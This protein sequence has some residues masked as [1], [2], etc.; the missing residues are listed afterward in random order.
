[1][2]RIATWAIAWAAK[3]A[4]GPFAR[5][6]ADTRAAQESLLATM[7]QRNRGTEYGRE[8]GFGGIRTLAE[9]A[10]RVPVVDYEDLRTRIERVTLGEKNV[11]TAEDP[12]LF[13]QTSGTTGKPKFIP[14]T[15]T[16]RKS[17]GLTVWLHY[18]RQDHPRM[19]RGRILTIVSP[20]V[21][22]YTDGNLP[23]GSTSGMV[24]KEMPAFVRS[25]YAVPYDAF[26]I[27]N[28]E[29]KYYALLRFGIASDVTFLATANPSSVLML[30]EMADRHAESLIR[31]I[32]DGALSNEFEIPP[33][34][35]ALLA[36]ALAAD[37]ARARALEAMRVRR[38]RLVPADYWPDLALLGCW[39]GGTVGSYI[40]KLDSWYDPD[41]KGMPP[42]RDMGYLASEAR[43][44]V[45]VS[46]RG[47]GGVLTIHNNVFELVPA[48]EVDERP[49]DHESWSY[50]PAA[51]A[52]VGREYYVFITT[53]GGL[54]RYDIND[55]IEVVDRYRT[56]PVVE[57]RRKGRGMTNMTGEK[58]SVN[59]LIDAMQ[60]AA[61]SVS[62]QLLHFRG[63][64]DFQESRYV[65][66]VELAGPLDG[67]RQ[68]ELLA[69]IDRELG[70]RNIEYQA[71]RNSDR[72]RPPVLQVMR[73]GWY[74][75]GKQK[76][77]DEGK[78]LFQAKTILLDA[79]QGYRPEPEELEAES[80]LGKH[81]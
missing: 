79:K 59:Q 20:A 34:I 74:E 52:E 47:S 2:S 77:V 73:Q 14:V 25:A 21:E 44:S 1:M 49:D 26:E 68:G 71:K 48:E 4:A 18:A 58:L 38:G 81:E 8:F 63:E 23:Y 53:P 39:K 3:R 32:R 7:M 9:Y 15:P 67:A 28:Y 55:V 12:V 76:L 62:A 54:Y 80:R 24:V 11:L 66:K 61:R 19:F 42:I 41:G 64:P 30:A 10:R 60:E 43:M 50:L 33:G 46:D 40:R 37:P 16:C 13:A 75:R 6:V 35:R 27:A 56:A 72:L 5:A 22:G 69:A 70:T 31:D 45:P 17:G 57:F 65:F 36:P 51:D 29:A 78:R